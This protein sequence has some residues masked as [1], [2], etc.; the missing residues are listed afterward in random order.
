LDRETADQSDPLGIKRVRTH[1]VPLGINFY[2]PFGF[3]AGFK[4]TYIDQEGKFHLQNTPLNSF[5]F[6]EDHF[7]VFD[8][9]INYRL[10]KRFGLITVG[11]KNLF[12]KS[13]NYQDS[14]PLNPTMQRKRLVY[15]KITLAF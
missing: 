10:P 15:G 8:A 5:K 6:G 11:A 3:S 14:D 2:H 9:S 12:D 1:R 13:F 4:V 7:W